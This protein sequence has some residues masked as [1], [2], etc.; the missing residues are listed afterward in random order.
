MY[1]DT[2][3]AYKNISFEREAYQ[4]QNDLDYLSNRKHYSWIKYVV[5]RK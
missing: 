4:N 5:E 3:L 2:K 1:R